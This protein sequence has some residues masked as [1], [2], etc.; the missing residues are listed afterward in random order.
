MDATND[1]KAL[2]VFGDKFKV[3]TV[4]HCYY[5]YRELLRRQRTR[6]PISTA[7]VVENLADEW[8]TTDKINTIH[9]KIRIK[10]VHFEHN[11]ERRAPSLPFADYLHEIVAANFGILKTLQHNTDIRAM[12]LR[13]V[14]QHTPSQLRC[15]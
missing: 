1:S 12:P 3:A 11:R 14:Y 9:T 7:T 2:E 6:A 13:Q 8:C 15:K 4:A 5:I 10:I